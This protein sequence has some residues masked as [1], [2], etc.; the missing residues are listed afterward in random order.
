MRAEQQILDEIFESSLM[1]VLEEVY[2]PIEREFGETK[3]RNKSKLFTD[4]QINNILNLL[5]PDYKDL[6]MTITIYKN[7]RQIIRDWIFTF[8]NY[9]DNETAIKT[10]RGS[11]CGNQRCGIISLFPFNYKVNKKLKEEVNFDTQRRLLSTFALI[12][13]VRHAY[14]RIHKEQKFNK[15]N[16]I[17]IDV[18]KPG[19]HS[20]WIERDANHFTQR[21][22]NKNKDK[23]NEILKINENW[24][25]TWGNFELKRR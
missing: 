6:G 13:E 4:G 21:F 14:Q 25:C 17:Y 15:L 20:Q 19:Y 7:K 2:S 1:N 3:I 8:K 9:F 23:I 5:H 11:I 10:I 18:D 22:M 16:E 12:H 24:V